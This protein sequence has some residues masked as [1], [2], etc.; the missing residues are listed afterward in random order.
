MANVGQVQTGIT[1][2]IAGSNAY[3]I[4]STTPHPLGDNYLVM[5]M[6]HTTSQTLLCA[7][8]LEQHTQ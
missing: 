2:S 8:A 5:A 1:S 3:T 7:L 4:A 6:P